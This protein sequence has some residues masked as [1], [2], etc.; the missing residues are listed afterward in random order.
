MVLEFAR[1]DAIF[2]SASQTR[3]SRAGRSFEHHMQR[4]F[5]DG[6]VRHEEQVVMG[7]RRP[8]FVLPDIK[9]LDKKGDAIIVSL[10]TTLRERWKQVGME[11]FGG[12]VFLATVDD[13]V[14]GDV[15]E[16]MESQKISLLVPESLKKSTETEY[17]K[18]AHVITFRQFFDHEIEKKRPVLL[19][20][21]EGIRMP[22][23]KGLP[24]N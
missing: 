8:D 4:L 9:T 15:I 6:R 5:Q 23:Q 11:R 10:K 1:L 3:K 22:V 7:G 2:L 16:E 20:P 24:L 18:Y 12:A 13:R 21:L 17:S 14:S 19:L